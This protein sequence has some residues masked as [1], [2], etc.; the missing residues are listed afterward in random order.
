MKTSLDSIRNINLYQKKAG[1]RFTID[2]VLVADFVRKLKPH[3]IA[4]IGAGNGVIGILLAKKFTESRVS[5]IE[6]Q[7]GLYE[8][9]KKNIAINGLGDRVSAYN[10]DA[11]E[12][13]GLNPFTPSSFDVIVSNPPFRKQRTGRISPYDEKAVAR[14]EIRMD[15]D[16]L[17]YATDYLLRPRGNMYIIY[18]PERTADL[19]EKMRDVHIEPKRARFIHPDIN[20]ESRMVLVEGIKTARASI[21]IEKPL[22]IYNSNEYTQEVRDILG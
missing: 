5:L 20:T 3:N 12:I 8:L 6:I 7:K 19:F 13:D 21:K 10:L 4:D 17:M 1:Y 9:C 11:A 2:S 22:F 16:R 15:L 14:H 18:H